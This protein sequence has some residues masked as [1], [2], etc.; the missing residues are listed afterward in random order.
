MAPFY[1]TVTSGSVLELDESLLKSME[2]GNEAEL[3]RLDERLKEAE[4]TEGESEISDILKA[5][6]NYLT[7]IGDKV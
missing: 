3:K 1:R 6:A 4:E 2:E 7:R 5:R